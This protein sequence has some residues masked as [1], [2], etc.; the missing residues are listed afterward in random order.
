MSYERRNKVYAYEM[1]APKTSIWRAWAKPVLFSSM[2]DF[3]YMDERFL[4]IPE[5]SA[6]K[7]SNKLE[8]D[9]MI[10][11]DLPG[12]AGVEEGIALAQKGCR[13]VPLYNGVCVNSGYLPVIDCENIV[14]ALCNATIQLERIVLEDDAMPVFLLDSN[15]M[16][17]SKK[18]PGRYDNRWSVF[19][20]DM[21]S[22]TFLQQN[23]IHKVVVRTD[24]IQDDLAHILYRYKEQGI[25]IFLCKGENVKS[26]DV[27]KPSRFKSLIYRYKVAVGLTRNSTGGFGGRIPDLQESSGGG[28][29]RYG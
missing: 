26:V 28:Y 23:G 21:P 12:K 5:L 2:E 27:T 24:K 8:S 1:W 17:G 13:P 22:A 14:S 15:R 20:Q 7:W 19:P 25:E 16:N 4:N 3:G 11:V 29:Y 6:L 9:S 10:I 18:Q